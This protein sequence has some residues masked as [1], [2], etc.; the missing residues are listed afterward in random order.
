VVIASFRSSFKSSYV[1]LMN[2]FISYHHPSDW[3]RTK[4]NRKTARPPPDGNMHRCFALDRYEQC[5]LQRFRKQPSSTGFGS[6][7]SRFV[8]VSRSVGGS[9][10]MSGS[11]SDIWVKVICFTTLVGLR[12]SFYPRS[13]VVVSLQLPE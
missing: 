2:I 7:F 3:I 6:R 13:G 8:M 5:S 9:R 11:F 12:F 1:E 10:D 4:H